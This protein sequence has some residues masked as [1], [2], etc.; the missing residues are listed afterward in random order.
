MKKILILFI[1]GIITAFC[2]VSCAAAPADE[3]LPPEHEPTVY[4]IVEIEDWSGMKATTSYS[5]VTATF[6]DEDAQKIANL[7]N[8]SELTKEFPALDPNWTITLHTDEWEITIQDGNCISAYDGNTEGAFSYDESR[9]TQLLA[10]LEGYGLL[11]G[12]GPR[13]PE[14]E[15]Q[16]VGTIRME[17]GGCFQVTCNYPEEYSA[18]LNEADS[19]EIVSLLNDKELINEFSACDS[20]LTLIYGDWT[21]IIH[22]QCGSV[23]AYHGELEGSC[24]LSDA[25]I[26]AL[27]GIL[28]EYEINTEG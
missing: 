3:P 11:P 10:I 25:E 24:E 22:S 27:R 23:G 2:L 13:P 28:A 18:A 20:D 21:F 4:G 5:N 1:L 9:D 15:I 8:G 26:S 14:T 19:S 16:T 17:E 7:L 12:D 6:F